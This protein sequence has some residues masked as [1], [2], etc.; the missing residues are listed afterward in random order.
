[1]GN[2]KKRLR[3]ARKKEIASQVQETFKF[4]ERRVCRLLSINRT[5][6]RY[7]PK[8]NDENEAIKKRLGELAVRWK[9]FGYKRL[10]ILL[11]REGYLVNHKRTYR[12]YKEAELTLRKRKKKSPAEK[13]GKPEMANSGVSRILCF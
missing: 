12:L 9:R 13:R 7:K 8:L 4:S 10:H 11:R 6:K 5:F 3:P 1:V 2:R